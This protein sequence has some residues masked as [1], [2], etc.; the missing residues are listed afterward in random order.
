[1]NG[2]TQ[3][4]Q[5]QGRMNQENQYPIQQVNVENKYLNAT[6]HT[7]GIKTDMAILSKFVREELFYVFV[8]DYKSENDDCLSLAC[9][10]FIAY[11]LE[12]DNKGLITNPYIQHASEKEFKAYLRF[13]WKE[14]LKTNWKGKGNIRRDLS[15]EKSAVYA[16]IADKFKSKYCLGCIWIVEAQIQH[17]C[18]LLLRNGCPVCGQRKGSNPCIWDARRKDYTYSTILYVLWHIFQGWTT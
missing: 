11:C 13:L 2:T 4:H 16:A 15:N 12:V 6:S 1:M 8:H 17:A 3:H 5:H 7:G 18:F 9:E 10:E 14:G